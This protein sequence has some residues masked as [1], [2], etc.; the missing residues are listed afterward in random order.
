[1]SISYKVPNSRHVFLLLGFLCAQRKP[2]S[3]ACEGLGGGVSAAPA[4]CDPAWP[5][6]SDTGLISGFYILPLLPAAFFP[7][8]SAF[9]LPQWSLN[10]LP[11]TQNSLGLN[12]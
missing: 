10:F 5:G 11:G 7:S 12:V 2:V 1:V 8:I 9:K 4:P 3:P 6:S